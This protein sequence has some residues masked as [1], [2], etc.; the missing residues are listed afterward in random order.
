MD[1][2]VNDAAASLRQRKVDIGIFG[3]LRVFVLPGSTQVRDVD[4]SVDL[5]DREVVEGRFAVLNGDLDNFARLDLDYTWS[6]G[7][8]IVTEA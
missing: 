1:L 6:E 7:K 8:L 5:V 4:I 3:C 2:Q